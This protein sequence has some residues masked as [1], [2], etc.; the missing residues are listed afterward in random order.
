LR[1]I[2]IGKIT[3]ILAQA[4]YFCEDLTE[5]LGGENVTSIEK[6]AFYATRKLKSLPFLSKVTSIE[7]VAFFGS[8]C[9]I[10]N[11]P[12][13]CVFGEYATYKQYNSTNY[14]NDVTFTP[15][16]N[17][18]NSLFHQK[19]PRWAEKQIGSYAFED[20]TPY[21]YGKNGCAL[22]TL[23]EIYSAYEGVHFNTPE[24]FIPILETK[25]LTHLDFRYRETWCQIANGLGYETELISSMTKEN[26]QKMYDALAQGALCYKSVGTVKDNVV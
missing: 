21:T 20:G 19:D 2:D 23:A 8:G 25:G 10:E 26:L 12:D 9:D 13:D 4:F 3:T 6:Y 22:I 17:Q 14:W 24:E 11:V 1:S 15:C 18:L 16:K 5:V 7:G